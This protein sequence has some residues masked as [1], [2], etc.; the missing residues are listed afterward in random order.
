MKLLI[1]LA[2]VTVFIGCSPMQS[3][4]LEATEIN[5]RS[6]VIIYREL[7]YIDGNLG[8]IFGANGNDYVK[9]GGGSY[10]SMYMRP[11]SHEFFVRSTKKIDEPYLVTL[12]LSA[13]DVTCLRAF[14]KVRSTAGTAAKVLVDGGLIGLLVGGG[15]STFNMEETECWSKEELDDRRAVAVEYAE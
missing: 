13:N 10:A 4:P 7:Q 6:E 3:K 8:L 12:D 2:A 14:N 5:N 1:V 15:S 11:G 9:L